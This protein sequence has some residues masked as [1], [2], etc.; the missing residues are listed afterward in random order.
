MRT[1]RNVEYIA[2][3]TTSGKSFH[4]FRNARNEKMRPADGRFQRRSEATRE[5]NDLPSVKDD[6][7]LTGE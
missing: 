5:F 1:W 2:L 3:S 6:L 7:S 4:V